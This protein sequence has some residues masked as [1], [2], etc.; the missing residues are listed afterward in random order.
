MVSPTGP[1]Q[2][3]TISLCFAH[4]QGSESVHFHFCRRCLHL[5][6]P[7]GMDGHR[8]CNATPGTAALPLS[9]QGCP[10]FMPQSHEILMLLF[11]VWAFFQEDFQDCRQGS[12]DALTSVWSVSPRRSELPIMNFDQPL[13]Y[14]LSRPQRYISP[15]S[16]PVQCFSLLHYIFFL[17]S[18][19]NLHQCLLGLLF[20]FSFFS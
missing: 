11:K 16:Q 4:S 20:L 9:S 7:V 6:C 13:I 3:V 10:H 2:A 19:G 18:K 8:C 1:S 17:V 14:S 12:G 15:P 5:V